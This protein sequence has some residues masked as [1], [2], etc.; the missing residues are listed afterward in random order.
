MSTDL[1]PIREWIDLLVVI[2]RK[3]AAVDRVWDVREPDEDA[4]EPKCY[5]SIKEPTSKDA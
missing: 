5:G 3:R 4:T 1:Y 2:D